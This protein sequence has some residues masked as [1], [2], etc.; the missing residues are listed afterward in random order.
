MTDE[1]PGYPQALAKAGVLA[2]HKIIRHKDGIYAIGD[3]YTNTGESA[4]S[5]LKRGIS[6]IRVFAPQAR[7]HWN[8]ASG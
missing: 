8:V 1:F 5:L 6:G 3:V 2:E 4:F 7:H